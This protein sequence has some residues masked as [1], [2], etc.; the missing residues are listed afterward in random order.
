MN[1]ERNYK[2]QREYTEWLS[3]ERW[4]YFFTG[5]FKFEGITPN[6]ARRAAER[7]FRGFPTKELVVLFIESGSLY[8]KVHLHG[9]LRF[10]I[11]RKPSAETIWRGWFDKYGRA[12]VE[13]PK[14]SEDVSSY[15]C[16][17]VTKEMKDE[18]FIVL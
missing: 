10:R 1:Y 2:L 14:S 13:V 16:K 9:L 6:G 5:T 11:D 8:G 17:Y 12:K 7:F 4:D 18:T 15:C 3:K